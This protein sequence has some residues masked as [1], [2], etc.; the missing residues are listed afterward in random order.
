M[1]Q[2]GR[3]H[4]VCHHWSW[5]WGLATCCLYSSLL[6][7]S[8][9]QGAIS[10]NGAQVMARKWCDLRL[11]AMLAWLHGTFLWKRWWFRVSPFYS[12]RQW[13]PAR[14]HRPANGPCDVSGM[15]N[16]GSLWVFF[17]FSPFLFVTGHA[18]FLFG[19]RSTTFVLNKLILTK[20]W[21][22]LKRATTCYSLR[23]G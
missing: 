4:S 17:F 14:P 22:V 20:R 12:S 8:S 15:S 18:G 1:P 16:C 9:R 5:T 21:L 19:D 10:Q 23:T 6:T 3:W 11:Q 13:L 2:L 7:L